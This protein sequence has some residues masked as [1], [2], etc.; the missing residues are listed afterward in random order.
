MTRIRVGRSMLNLHGFSIGL[1]E[2]PECICH[3]KEESPQHYF[4]D[5]FLY[6]QERQTLFS[7]IEHYIPRFNKLSKREK[8]NIIIMGFDIDNEENLHINTLLTIAVQN[9]IL[10]KKFEVS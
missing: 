2:T 5:C 7:L 8:T 4:I 3:A 9:F 1:S 10:Q 6:S